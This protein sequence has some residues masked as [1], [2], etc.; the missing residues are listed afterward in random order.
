MLF[1][2]LMRRQLRPLRVSFGT[3][4][5]PAVA[6][7]PARAAERVTPLPAVR[8]LIPPVNPNLLHDGEEEGLGPDPNE[9]GTPRWLRPSVRN[10]RGGLRELRQRD[11]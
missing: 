1:A 9:A 3:R 5:M 10:A 7:V 4:A 6:E 11:W 2:F 8:E